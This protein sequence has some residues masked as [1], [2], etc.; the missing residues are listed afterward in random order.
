MHLDLIGPYSK[1]IIQQQPGGAIIKNNVSLTYMTIIEPTTGWFE[2]VEVLKYDLDEVTG[3]NDKYIDNSYA[4]VSQLFNKIWLSRFHP[5]KIV[6]D[7]RSE[8][9]QDF[10]RLN[11]NKK[12]KLPL[13]WSGCT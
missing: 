13:R 1:S 12:H 7:N 10:T 6:F 3:G 2:I 4:R 9:K 5:Q 11:N 8:F